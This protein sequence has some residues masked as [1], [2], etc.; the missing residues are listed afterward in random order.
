MSD[1]LDPH[2]PGKT[3]EGYPAPKRAVLIARNRLGLVLLPDRL[4]GYPAYKPLL[5]QSI[6]GTM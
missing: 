5:I 2:D 3:V 4:T 1:F 6:A